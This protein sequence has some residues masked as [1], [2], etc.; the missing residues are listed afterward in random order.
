L[1]G[2]EEQ[3]AVQAFITNQEDLLSLYGF[4]SARSESH[5]EAAACKNG[6]L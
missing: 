4:V 2:Y 6:F 1:K 5:E 3:V